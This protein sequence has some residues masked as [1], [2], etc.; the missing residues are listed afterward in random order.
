M[1]VEIVRFQDAF[2]RPDALEDVRLLSASFSSVV[3]QSTMWPVPADVT[4][5]AVKE[6]SSREKAAK[7]KDFAKRVASV[8]AQS[9]SRFSP[10]CSPAEHETGCGGGGQYEDED[11]RES[12]LLEKELRMIVKL[13]RHQDEK[14][15]KK[16]SAAQ[17]KKKLQKALKLKKATTC[18]R[19]RESVPVGPVCVDPE[20]VGPEPVVDVV[21][22]EPAVDAFAPEPVARAAAAAPVLPKSRWSYVQYGAHGCFAFKPGQC[23]AHCQDQEHLDTPPFKCHC[24]RTTTG[25]SKPGAGRVLGFLALWLEKGGRVP[26]EMHASVKYKKSLCTREMRPARIAA[27]SRLTALPEWDLLRLAEAPAGADDDSKPEAVP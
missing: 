18:K 27:R 6:A 19:K 3:S 12:A 7:G 10:F 24:D 4:A 20:P 17:K 1:S 2:T 8:V 26:R 13:Y 25:G 15:A 5:A 16:H 9:D 11:D 22:P 14:A 21:V 23:H